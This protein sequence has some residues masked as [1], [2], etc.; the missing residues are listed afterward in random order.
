MATAPNGTWSQPA[1]G[2]ELNWAWSQPTQVAVPSPS[3]H[4]EEY[5]PSTSLEDPEGTD[6]PD[7]GASLARA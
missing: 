2:A 3:H 7:M 5:A 1:Q 6:G 4:W